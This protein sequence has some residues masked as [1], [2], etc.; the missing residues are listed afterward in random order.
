MSVHDDD[1]LDFD[2][3]DEDTRER[4]P[5]QAGD[6]PGRGGDGRPSAAAAARPE[7]A[8]RRTG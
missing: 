3:V 1:I 4:S 8:R 5:V 7:A 2:F 6:S